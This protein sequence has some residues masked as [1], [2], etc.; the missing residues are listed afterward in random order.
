MPLIGQNRA[1]VC[2]GLAAINKN[3][4]PSIRAILDV[5]GKKPGELRAS[6]VSYMIVPRLNAAGRMDKANL[7]VDLLMSDD[8]SQSYNLAIELESYN[9]QRR[10]ITNKIIE[11]AN[12]RATKIL[13]N[14][15]DVKSLV[16]Y[17]KS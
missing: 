12:Y 14:S 2:E 8:Y 7:A 6:D 13:E 16:L 3:P 4:R 15:P 17:D 11:D 5:A 1:L 9:N 10:E